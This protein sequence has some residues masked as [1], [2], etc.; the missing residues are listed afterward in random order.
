MLTGA[1]HGLTKE[2][3][4]IDPYQVVGGDPQRK[5]PMSER[6]LQQSGNRP[7][8]RLQDAVIVELFERHSEGRKLGGPIQFLS[9]LL[10]IWQLNELQFACALLGYEK[11]KRVRVKNILD[12]HAQLETRDEKD[13][14]AEL[15]VIRRILHG[16]F[17]D[18]NVENQWLRESQDILDGKSPMD[19]LLEG[20][21]P[22]L[23][24]VRQLVEL[25]AGL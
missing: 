10:E 9:K 22:N 8:R 6:G 4:P 25:M 17:R 18:I 15:F 21:W 13:R 3:I 23:L 19:L 1:Q 12:G 14:I 5:A 2:T 7:K 11:S 24:R 20:S 16:I